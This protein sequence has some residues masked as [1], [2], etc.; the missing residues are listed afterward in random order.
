MNEKK[1]TYF[2][3]KKAIYS[4]ALCWL[5]Y[6]V[7]YSFYISQFRFYDENCAAGLMSLLIS[8][9]GTI[10]VLVALFWFKEFFKANLTLSLA[11]LVFCSPILVITGLHNYKQIFG[12]SASWCDD[13]QQP[14]ECR[15]NLDTRE[16]N[17]F[18]N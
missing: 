12:E 8:I 7:W 5:G 6:V 14:I 11:F 16:C 17:S 3:L 1:I 18:K 10:L 9:L 15:G 2:V 13:K 4:L